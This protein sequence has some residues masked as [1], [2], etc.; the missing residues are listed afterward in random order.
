MYEICI[1][2]LLQ[3]MKRSQR[4]PR[5]G[6]TRLERFTERFLTNRRLERTSL[7]ISYAV[8]IAS[9]VLN[10]IFR[11]IDDERLTSNGFDICLK[12]GE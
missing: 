8:A 12:N 11:F 6:R 3:R 1:F 7:E 4:S 10:I 9:I 2:E 5:P